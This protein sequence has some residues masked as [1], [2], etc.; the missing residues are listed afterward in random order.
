VL[1]SVVISSV[2]NEK[3]LSC[4]AGFYDENEVVLAKTTL[5]DVAKKNLPDEKMPRIIVRKGGNK[6]KADCEDIVALYSLL[7]KEKVVFPKILSENLERIPAIQAGD[8][9]M[10]NILGSISEL[11]NVVKRS[12]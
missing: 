9:D 6:V 10:V 2:P 3:L 11:K 8:C 12:L 7:D 5:F 4:I 1:N